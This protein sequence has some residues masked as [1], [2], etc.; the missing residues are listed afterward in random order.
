MRLQRIALIAD[1]TPGYV[2]GVIRGIG[3]RARPDLP[4]LF[5]LIAPSSTTVRRVCGEGVDGAIV[6]SI[7]PSIGDALLSSNI[8]SVNTG[9]LDFAPDFPHVGNDDI[10][11]GKM[12]A[13][14]F[15]DRGFVHLAYVGIAARGTDYPIRRGEGFS[16]EAAKAGSTVAVRP[17]PGSTGE[18][19]RW[20]QELPEPT[21]VLA[22]NDVVAW[23][24]VE[25][26]RAVGRSI[27]E[28]IAVLG[29]DDDQ[30]LCH[31]A[32]PSLSSIRVASQRIGIQAADILTGMLARPGWRPERMEIPPVGVAVRQSTE[33]F[34][35]AD[36]IV[37]EAL[38]WIERRAA[39][40]ISVNQIAAHVAVSRRCLEQRFRRLLGRSP[41]EEIER[42]RLNMAREMLI[43]TTLSL[44]DVARLCGFGVGKRLST[45][46]HKVLGVPPSALRRAPCHFASQNGYSRHGSY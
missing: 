25:S 11:I 37:A 44:G 42:V 30:A 43:D 10:A 14:H 22:A 38:R 17:I 45:V 13:R 23:Q 24:V 27:P 6:M 9:P 33:I 31:L 32:Y 16:E 20:L 5:D 39:C 28:Q 46:F 40:A 18:L 2:E 7:T 4:W 12:A 36:P 29:V 3:M 35:V 15:L 8:P 21:G 34:A 19:G 26:C 1:I 41:R